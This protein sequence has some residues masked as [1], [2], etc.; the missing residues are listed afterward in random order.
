MQKVPLLLV[1]ALG[2]GDRENRMI[3]TRVDAQHFQGA[4]I[5]TASA[6]AS[7][8]AAAVTKDG[9]LYSWGRTVPLSHWQAYPP[10]T[11]TPIFSRSVFRACPLGWILST[12][13]ELALG[14]GTHFAL[15]TPSPS[16]CASTNAW[17]RSV[18]KLCKMR[19]WLR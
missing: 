1:C 19:I 7:T 4:K 16:T 11:R 18:L 6:F 9:V 8:S 15:S 12:W 17:A 3:P 13:R 14:V 10:E 2:V 5:V